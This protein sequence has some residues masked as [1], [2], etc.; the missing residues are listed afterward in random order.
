MPLPSELPNFNCFGR[1]E[2]EIWT[3]NFET[4]LSL[5]VHQDPLLVLTS[6]P[7]TLAIEVSFHTQHRARRSSRRGTA[8]E[9][10][11][12][13]PPGI[14]SR[15]EAEA[16]RFS[17]R[18]PASKVLGTGVKESQLWPLMPDCKATDRQRAELLSAK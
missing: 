3:G 16:P 8:T 4:Q 13:P 12:V 1:M 17:G 15:V 14:L 7:K 10:R 18:S 9:E 2:K 11:G 6:C 5:C